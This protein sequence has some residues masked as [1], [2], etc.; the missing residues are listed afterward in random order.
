MREYNNELNNFDEKSFTEHR[1]DTRLK[2]HNHQR[3]C[4]E[5]QNLGDNCCFFLCSSLDTNEMNHSFSQFILQRTVAVILQRAVIFFNPNG[6]FSRSFLCK[7]QLRLFSYSDFRMNK[8][9]SI[10]STL[11]LQFSCTKL[12]NRKVLDLICQ[13]FSRMIRLSNTLLLT[14]S[15]WFFELSKRMFL[16]FSLSFRF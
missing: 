10:R 2:G 14:F 6:L 5:Q 1:G 7:G 12:L 9:A 15:L 13:Q 3:L 11:L 8:F 16:I 4:E